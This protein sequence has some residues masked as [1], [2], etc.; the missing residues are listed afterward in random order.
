MTSE[1]RNM[2]L[3]TEHNEVLGGDLRVLVDQNREIWFV[4]S[5]VAKM[6]GYE[7]TTQMV[8]GLDADEKGVHKVGTLGGDQNA[9]II[10]EA[11]LYQVIM[12]A[13]TERV[14]PF[15]RWVTHEVLPQIR[16]TGKYG[17]SAKAS[18]DPFDFYMDR[19]EKLGRVGF[20]A[21]VQQAYLLKND[22]KYFDETANHF[23]PD[24]AIAEA[25]QTV[26]SLTFDVRDETSFACI[27]PDA[28]F[29]SLTVSQIAASYKDKRITTKV[30][31]DWLCEG[32]YQKRVARGKYV[33]LERA[34]GIAV[35]PEVFE[36]H[37]K[38]MA[39][40]KSWR[41]VAELQKYLNEC[42]VAF[43]NK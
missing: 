34:E 7:K 18:A 2:T 31:N 40:I 9:T 43:T 37:T 30:I 19:A 10:T 22:A 38:G 5:D 1:N 24:L 15:K 41:W 29:A 16:K 6:L 23:L 3:H 33:K 21:G 42:F 11:G 13:K 32:G 26:K 14:K 28:S 8:R 25:K 36:G 20:S 35:S 39:I 27:V 12:S 4:A 17:V